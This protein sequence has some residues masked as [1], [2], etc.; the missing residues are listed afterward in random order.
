MFTGLN[1]RTDR[2]PHGGALRVHALLGITVV[3]TFIFMVKLSEF[4]TLRSLYGKCLLSLPSP[5]STSCTQ[6]PSPAPL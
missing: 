5:S 2:Y 3:V 6:Y 4:N 1:Q